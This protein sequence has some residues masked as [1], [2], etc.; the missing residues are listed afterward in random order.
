METKRFSVASDVW[1]FGITAIEILDSG[2]R[3][4]DKMSN[5]EVINRVAQGYRLPQPADCPEALY[6]LLLWCWNDEVEQR[7]S[8]SDIVKNLCLLQESLQVEATVHRSDKAKNNW[9]RALKLKDSKSSPSKFQRSISNNS[10]NPSYA[11]LPPLSPRIS[12]STP[13]VGA[14]SSGAAE[15]SAASNEYDFGDDD[16]VT[17]DT[18]R[19]TPEM[20][21]LK[22]TNSRWGKA[23]QAAVLG[24]PDSTDEQRLNPEPVDQANAA[25]SPR[26]SV[27]RLERPLIS[28]APFQVHHSS[29]EDYEKALG[30]IEPAPV[31]NSLSLALRQLVVDE[32]QV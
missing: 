17:V 14:D 19:I 6:E 26:A 3:P 13:G 32:T 20:E 2:A 23:R 4:Y 27:V 9:E 18:Q 8:F 11:D 22:A 30:Y 7:P 15:R 25:P 16:A 5:S 10:T 31:D 28:S 24:G 1:S 21:M 12:Y 29:S